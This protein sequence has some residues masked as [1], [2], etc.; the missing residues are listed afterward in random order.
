MPAAAQKS[1]STPADEFRFEPDPVLDIARH[2]EKC[3][4]DVAGSH[5]EGRDRASRARPEL[6][7]ALLSQLP[8]S[9]AGLAAKL[10]QYEAC[11]QSGDEHALDLVRSTIEDIGYMVGTTGEPGLMVQLGEELETAI[12]VNE[13]VHGRDGIDSAR[14]RFAF[15]RLELL[16][17]TILSLRADDL[18]D[19]AI[20]L[21]CLNTF[22]NDIDDSDGSGERGDRFSRALYSVLAVVDRL[23]NIPR[24][25]W[26]GE[27]YLPLYG[28]EAASE[29]RERFEGRASSVDD[30][31][32]VACRTV[33]QTEVAG[34]ARHAETQAR[35]RSL[36][37]LVS[38]WLAL[39]AAASEAE[40]KSCAA[41]AVVKTA[42]FSIYDEAARPRADW[43][44]WDALAAQREEIGEREHAHA[45]M[46]T[47]APVR[48]T[49]DMLAKLQFVRAHFDTTDEDPFL[50]PHGAHALDEIIR[51]LMSGAVSVTVAEETG[52]PHVS[53]VPAE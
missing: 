34:A 26:G 2:L 42:G 17:N 16:Q 43:K 38:E 35:A 44:R 46:I 32:E 31:V 30:A 3:S 15:R 8:L 51:S 25:I 50:W 4:D 29:R 18:R 12:Q 52:R 48:S 27:Y 45:R 20:Q 21:R 19:A 33:A 49:E 23:L 28:D 6:I 39:S 9:L 40:R 7:D 14:G 24:N 47:P 1:A 37:D 5:A 11:A 13:A 22:R 41:A 36:L 10:G 53:A